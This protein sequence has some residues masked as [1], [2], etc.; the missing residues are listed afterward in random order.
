MYRCGPFWGCRGGGATHR[1]IRPDAGRAASPRTD[2]GS[3]G[4]P[5]PPL[6][7][8]IRVASYN[9]EHFTDGRNDG[10]ERTPEVFMT[11]A[12]AAAALIAEANP[13]I[14]VL[15]EIENGRT[16][17][18]LND[19][20]ADP[21]PCIYIS[22]LRHSSGENEKLNLALLSRLRPGQV[23][24]LSFSNL[25]G[26]GRPTRGTLSADFDL[27]GGA[28]LLVYDIHLKSNFGEAPRNQAQRAIALH[29]IAAD[30]VSENLRNLPASTSALILGDTNV[31]PDS[32]AFAAD[33]SLEPLAGSYVD[34][35]RGRPIAERTTIPTRQPGET[36]D[37]LMVFPP[38]AFDRVFASKNLA[39]D[40]PWR[41]SP[42]QAIQK[43]TDTANNLTPPGLNGHVSD[44]YLVYVD[45]TRNP[46]YIPPAPTWP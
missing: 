40:G 34:L 28:K 20:F 46:D 14:L 12:R 44:H 39:G 13:D 37:P 8:R 15:Q 26:V 32:D 3:P 24:Q 4:A 43:G 7:D 45:L 36:G 25:A 42:P 41:V 11:H 6:P 30:A 5:A 2:R 22:K 9:L 19:Q 27:G 21:Y 31:D 17:E 38:A 16:L 23:R 35:W 29:H 1:P 10:P 33:P 18:F